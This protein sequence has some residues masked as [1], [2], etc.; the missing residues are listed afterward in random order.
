MRKFVR[1]ARSL[2]DCCTV[3]YNTSH[4]SPEQF[5]F[6]CHEPCCDLTSNTLALVGNYFSLDMVEKSWENRMITPRTFACV[7]YT[8]HMHLSSLGRLP[9]SFPGSF[10]FSLAMGM[11]RL[12][13]APSPR[14]GNR[15]GLNSIYATDTWSLRNLKCQHDAMRRMISS[16]TLF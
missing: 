6:F 14:K 5:I 13:Q 8:S 11:C 9:G 12:N 1:L 2:M 10:P 4:S 7:N 3:E 15:L 16:A